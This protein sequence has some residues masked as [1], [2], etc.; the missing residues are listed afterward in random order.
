MK[1][2]Q[3]RDAKRLLD[4]EVADDLERRIKES[5]FFVVIG[6]K[7]YFQSAHS[8]AESYIAKHYKK[9]FRILIASDAI[10]PKQFI[11]GVKD[12]IQ[13]KLRKHMDLEQQI[14]ELIELKAN[15]T[16]LLDRYNDTKLIRT[17]ERDNIA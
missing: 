7:K 1:I 13:I 17:G 8:D 14:L 11:Q 10:V 6:T 15:E 4:A 2:T 9:P 16:N 3:M 5:E 12:I